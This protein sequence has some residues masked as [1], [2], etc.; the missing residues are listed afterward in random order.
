MGAV[1]QTLCKGGKQ[2][3]LTLAAWREAGELQL[4]LGA[5]GQHPAPK[6]SAGP[7]GPVAQ[8]PLWNEVNTRL[9]AH[10]VAAQGQT[11]AVVSVL[12]E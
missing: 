2:A 3:H 8:S 1:L 7:A 9:G 4:H 11:L 12:S 6:V 10:W 5:W